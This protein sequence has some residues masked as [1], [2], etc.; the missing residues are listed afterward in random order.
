MRRLVE[1]AGVEPASDIAP[2]PPS[3]SVVF[4]FNLADQSTEDRIL[5]S[6]PTSVFRHNQRARLWRQPLEGYAPFGA[7]GK[8]LGDRTLN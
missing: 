8:P 3:T 6:Q 1:A 7:S 5:T 2:G 4:R